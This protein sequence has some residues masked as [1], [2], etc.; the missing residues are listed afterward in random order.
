MNAPTSCARVMCDDS[1]NSTSYQITPTTAINGTIAAVW[2]LKEWI[3]SPAV[4]IWFDLLQSGINPYT[5][6]CA[7]RKCLLIKREIATQDR[8]KQRTSQR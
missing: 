2:E 7:L 6:T 4:W 8:K 5:D 3:N 1:P